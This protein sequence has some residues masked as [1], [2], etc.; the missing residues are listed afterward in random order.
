M[1]STPKRL[2]DDLPSIMLA[3]KKT[4]VPLTW[5]TVMTFSDTVTAGIDI[6]SGRGSIANKAV[7]FSVWIN[8]PKKKYSLSMRRRELKL[9]IDTFRE[10]LRTLAETRTS[11]EPG[12]S[13]QVRPAPLFHTTEPCVA[14]ILKAER[15]DGLNTS[16]VIVPVADIP[17]LIV[18]FDNALSVID[19]EAFPLSEKTFRVAL[20]KAYRKQME[21]EWVTEPA[22][23]DV[24]AAV[25]RVVRVMG[26]RMATDDEE[27]LW[28]DMLP[29]M[30]EVAV[31]CEV[32]VAAVL[33]A[34]K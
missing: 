33:L 16:Q 25:D 7:L 29:D 27:K 15:S 34:D 1:S 10:G 19:F 32:M 4:S 12:R 30:T 21:G 11:V 20:E 22:A 28:G 6:I 17:S 2:A 18:S 24:E 5:R 13:I 8:T 9:V 23:A 31:K 26:C 3:P 14:I